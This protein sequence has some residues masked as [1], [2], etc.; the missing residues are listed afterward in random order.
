[1]QRAIPLLVFSDLDGTLLDHETYGWEKA[2]PALRR[3]AVLGAPVVLATSKTA[4]ET[5]VLQAKM[6]LSKYPAIVENGAGLIGR[7]FSDV[8]GG[9]EYQRLRECLD[10]MPPAM[11]QPFKGFGDMSVAEVSGMT[12]LS[13]EIAELAR[14]RSFSEPGLWSGSESERELFL[15][16]LTDLGISARAGGRFLT[17]SFGK[18]KKDR[19]DEVQKLYLPAKTIALGDAPNDVEMLEHAD[20]GFIIANP[21]HAPLP[22]LEGEA[23]G[24]IMRTTLIGPAGWN[25]AVNSVLDHSETIAKDKKVG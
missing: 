18:T 24:R 16:A 12:G 14:K 21:A 8:S 3:L 23:E 15:A 25:E 1:M 6:G 13:P 7:G 10:T 19:M 17:L 5:V 9:E 22:N 20:F 2:R 11:R 4:A